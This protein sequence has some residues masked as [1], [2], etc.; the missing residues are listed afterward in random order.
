M[1]YN[2]A[3]QEDCF[4]G[5]LGWVVLRKIADDLGHVRFWKRK[6]MIS[7]VSVP[8]RGEPRHA[9]SLVQT[10]PYA[11]SLDLLFNDLLVL[12]WL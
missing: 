3:F 9:I 2:A 6:Y 10:I 7:D 11:K 5:V 4:F 1:F 8:T 12:K